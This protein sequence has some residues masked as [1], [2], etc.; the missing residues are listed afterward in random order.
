MTQQ[1]RFQQPQRT[2]T[3][4][5]SATAGSEHCTGSGLG[6]LQGS[7]TTAMQQAGIVDVDDQGDKR[8]ESGT[9][10]GTSGGA[11]GPQGRQRDANDVRETTLGLSPR[12]YHAI[13]PRDQRA[14]R[15]LVWRVPVRKGRYPPSERCYAR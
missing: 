13:A 1:R 6:I 7:M 5:G 14:V 3:R 11:G 12:A 10:L 8:V 9:L 4:C 2:T 15:R